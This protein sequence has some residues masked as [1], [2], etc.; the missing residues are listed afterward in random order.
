MIMIVV[1]QLSFL[2]RFFLTKQTVYS[3]NRLL[4]SPIRWYF[5]KLYTTVH[6]SASNSIT[7]IVAISNGFSD[8][9]DTLIEFF[10]S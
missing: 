6:L 7:L 10:T 1:N 9:I 8:T 4:G 3:G 2:L 5:Q